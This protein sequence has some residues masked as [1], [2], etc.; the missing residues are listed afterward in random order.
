MPLELTDHA[1]RQIERGAMIFEA[2]SNRLPA[3]HDAAV[4]MLAA[5]ILRESSENGMDRHR[6][7]IETPF[8]DADMVE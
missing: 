7:V 6:L 2:L 4:A 3:V 1:R 5:E 8:E